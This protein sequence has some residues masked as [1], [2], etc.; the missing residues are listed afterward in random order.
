M[1]DA[2]VLDEVD[3]RAFA[4]IGDGVRQVIIAADDGAVRERRNV[5][6]VSVFGIDF[7][8]VDREVAIA[9]RGV[10]AVERDMR[11]AANR[12]VAARP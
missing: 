1:L 7:R 11:V 8:C 6:I 9:A 10:F 2:V 12:Q 4:I 3:G 5:F